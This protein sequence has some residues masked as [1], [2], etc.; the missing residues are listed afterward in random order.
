M[1]LWTSLSSVS[2]DEEQQESNPV[3]G[4][5]HTANTFLSSYRRAVY[6]PWKLKALNQ[7]KHYLNRLPWGRGSSRSWQVLPCCSAQSCCLSLGSTWSSAPCPRVRS[8]A[9]QSASLLLCAHPSSLS[10]AGVIISK[11]LG[12]LQARI[13]C[14]LWFYQGWIWPAVFSLQVHHCMSL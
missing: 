4:T 7:I 10:Q 3:L 5:S 11:G 6:F 1:Y 9:G 13:C 12:R 14:C 8:R 2:R